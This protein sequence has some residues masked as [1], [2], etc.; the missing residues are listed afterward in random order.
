[1][2]NRDPIPDSGAR[3]RLLRQ[4]REASLGAGILGGGIAQPRLA[5]RGPLGVN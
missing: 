5:R 1:V 2:C 4:L 3:G